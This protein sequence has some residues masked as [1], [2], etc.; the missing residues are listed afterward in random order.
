MHMNQ[1]SASSAANDALALAGRILLALMFLTAGLKKIGGFEG[2]VG[3]IASKGLPMAS[4]LAVGT[5]LVEVVGS[6]ALIVGWKTRW[7]G[8]ALA[9]F[10]LV[11]SFIFHNYWAMP[12][13]MQ[14]TQTLMFWKNISVA[15]GMLMVAAFGAGAFSLDGRGRGA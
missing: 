11:A 8:L 6:V 9:G 15:G 14:G 4:L 12:A 2:T 5:I 1:N 7:A 10:T 13:E 3:Y